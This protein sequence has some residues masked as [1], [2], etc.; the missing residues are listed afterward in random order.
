M[1]RLMR[2]HARS[3]LIKIL[4][5]IIVVVFVF[6][7]AGSFREQRSARI[8]LV[9]GEPITREEFRETYNNILEQ[10]RQRFG[11]N[12]ND[13]LLKMFQVEKQAIDQ[14]INQKL[15]IKE[16]QKF[17]FRVSNNEVASSIRKIRAF[18]NAGTFDDRLYKNVLSRY[19]LTPEGFEAK[20]KE[21]IL[22]EKL[23]SLITGGVKVSDHEIFEW[24]KWENASVN[25]EFVL[26]EPDKYKDINSSVE[27]INTYFDKHKESYKTEPMV[28][29]HFLRFNPETYKSKVKIPD[30]EIQDY[31]ETNTDE[32]KNPK[33]VEA[34]HILIKTDQDASPENVEK[35]RIKA[36]NIHKMAL[37]GKDF[38]ELA[39]QYSEGPTKDKGGHL[40]AFKKGSMVKPFEDKAFSMK[41]GEISEP[42]RTSFGWHIIKVEKVNEESML[43]LKEAEIKIRKKLTDKHSKFIAYD[44]AEAV[45]DTVF[46]GDDLVKTAKDRD[47][48][49][50]TTE[51]FTRKGPEKEVKNREKFASTA[52]SLKTM[53]ISDI[54]DLG[55]G[56]YIIQILEKIPEKIPEFNDIKEKVEADLM[57]EKQDEKASNDANAFL[58]A[59]KNGGSMG[60]EIKKYNLVPTTTG[61]FKRYDSIPNIG[62][63]QEITNSAFIL[64][65]KNQ[66]A[67]NVIKGK[68]GYYVFRFMERKEPDHEGFDKE[69]GQIKEKLLQEKRLKT[70]DAW[71]TKIKNRSEISINEDIL[72]R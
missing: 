58:S 21:S 46:E 37:E 70:F 18:Q 3:W 62:F 24:F 31:Y 39:K 48:K 52:F 56:Y 23:N 25:I 60:T 53:E 16:A 66:L 35:G 14:L 20:Q 4:L 5:G 67:E 61:L 51:F 28:K 71:L 29:V 36:L 34:R 13:D 45:Y 43:S 33:T 15:L 41:A 38:A 49:L 6:W 72:N 26:F 9:N 1:L 44:E 57:K 17:N 42:V 68:K 64:S 7:G 55:D 63:E 40:G 30:E 59:L 10:L 22:I 11:N 54:Q 8:A 47:L 12:L 19:R 32:F 50:L 65:E 27:E 2:D 69:K